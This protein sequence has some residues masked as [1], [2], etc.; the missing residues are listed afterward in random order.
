MGQG[1]SRQDRALRRAIDRNSTD[2]IRQI[3]SDTPKAIFSKSFFKRRP[4]LSTAVKGGNVITVSTLLW[5]AEH[6]LGDDYNRFI[7]EC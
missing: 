4:L 7:N 1:L 3:V 6:H 5:A 2:S